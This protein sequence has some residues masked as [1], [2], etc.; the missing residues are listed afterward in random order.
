MRDFKHWS[1][2]FRQT[3]LEFSFQQLKDG[4]EML[5]GEQLGPTKQATRSEVLPDPLLC[6]IHLA[7]AKLMRLSGAAGVLIGMCEDLEEDYMPIPELG[8]GGEYDNVFLDNI[9]LR[10]V[11]R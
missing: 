8:L 9:S 6:S 2:I 10:L 4:D 11:A 5:F 3:G 7:I 1:Y